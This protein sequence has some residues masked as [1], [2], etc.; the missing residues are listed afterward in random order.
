MF[1]DALPESVP[2]YGLSLTIFIASVGIISVPFVLTIDILPPKVR[3]LRRWNFWFP[4]NNWLNLQIRSLTMTLTAMQMWLIGFGTNFAYLY[5][6]QVIKLYGCLFVF[7]SSC[8]VFALFVLLFIP[9]T[10]GKSHETI[11]RLLEKWNKRFSK[12]MCKT[13]S[14]RLDNFV[15]ISLLIATTD[16]ASHS[17]RENNDNVKTNCELILQQLKFIFVGALSIMKYDAFC[18]RQN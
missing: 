1:K 8:F 5:L 2:M 15:L 7:S 10:K 12:F 11:R 9:E 16:E 18:N 6:L 3:T 13:V 17:C 14:V 4:A